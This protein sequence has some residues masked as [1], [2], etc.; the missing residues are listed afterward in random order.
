MNWVLTTLLAVIF[1]TIANLFDKFVV[2][3]ELRDPIFATV[4]SGIGTFAVFIIYALTK[5]SVFTHPDNAVFAIIIGL[6]Y[7]LGILLYY[8]AVQM[9]EVSRVI[10]VLAI[11]P[12]FTLLMGYFL[13]GVVRQ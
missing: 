1:V 13:E 8:H 3:K 2:T 4:F 6:I 5:G 9:E 10:P 12:L 7:N 11:A